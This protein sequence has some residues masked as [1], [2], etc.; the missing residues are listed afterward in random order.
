MGIVFRQ[1]AKNTLVAIAGAILGAITI[2]LYTKY[3]SKQQL[4]FTR[5]ITN[6]VVTISQLLL[7]GLNSVLVV[8]IHSY[9]HDTRKKSLL[10]TLC[11]SL[12]IVFASIFAITYFFL[13]SWILSHFQPDDKPFM[14]KYF[15]WL[16]VFTFFFIYMVILEQYLGSQM[17]IAI[18]AFMRE[19]V[20][21]IANIMLI[22]LFAFGYIDF[23]SL[24]SGSI[25]IYLLPLIAFF[26]LCLRTKDFRC[27]LRLRDFTIKEY[28]ELIHFSWYHFLFSISVLLI[29]YMDTILLPLYDH[30]GFSLVAVYSIAVFLISFSQIPYRALLAPSFTALA[31]A[32]A[33][34]NIEKTKNI[35]IRSTINI[36]IPTIAI[37]I[38][39]CCN[40]ENVVAVI[41]NGYSEVAPVFLILILGSIINISTGMN[42]QVLSIAKYYKF[43]FYLSALLL[44][45]LFLLLRYLIQHY[46][47]YGAAWSTTLTL[48]LF[49]FIKFLFVWKKL[50]MQ[51]FSKN[52]LLVLIA[53]LPAAAAGYFFP[54]FF[55]QAHHVYIRTFADASLRSLAIV[56]VYVAMLI[57]LKPSADLEEYLASV[58]KNKRLF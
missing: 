23:S 31:K 30:R 27:S 3:L 52:T 41:K 2:W 55:D 7:L 49:N 15:T 38:I 4:G 19:V 12:P 47:I 34:N 33:E 24:F 46:G 48:I 44:I 26:V 14:E 51:P 50:H 22:F 1:S 25:L 53:A 10:L 37:S 21:R 32:F 11:L 56:I 5:N 28:K 36:L 57:W 17:K 29:G 35:F 40:I 18:S 45:V 54:H 13:R 42:D 9:A 16:P 39:L 20:L 43:S 6:Y 8:Y 58:R